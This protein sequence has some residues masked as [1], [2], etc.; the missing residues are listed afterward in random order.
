MRAGAAE[1]DG[2]GAKPWRARELEGAGRG[3]G[4]GRARWLGAGRSLAGARQAPG[5]RPGRGSCVPPCRD[6]AWGPRPARTVGCGR[7]DL[8]GEFR[9]GLCREHGAPSPAGAPGPHPAGWH[10]LPVLVQ[11]GSERVLSLPRALRPGCWAARQSLPAGGSGRLSPETGA[12]SPRLPGA[13]GSVQC[14]CARGPE[15]AALPSSSLSCLHPALPPGRRSERKTLD[16]RP[17]GGLRPGLSQQRGSGSCSSLPRPSVAPAAR[18]AKQLGG[19]WLGGRGE[20]AVARTPRGPTASEPP[21]PSP[22]QSDAVF[23]DLER[24]KSRPAHLGV[25]LRYLFSQ[26]DPGPLVRRRR[27]PAPSARWCLARRCLGPTGPAGRLGTQDRTGGPCGGRL[28]GAAGEPD[29]NDSGRRGS[30]EEVCG[31]RGQQGRGPRGAWAGRGRG[32]EAEAVSSEPASRPRRGCGPPLW[33][34]V[35]S[36]SAAACSCSL[37]G[38]GGGPRAWAVLPDGAGTLVT[39][40]RA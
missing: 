39:E 2:V 16:H 38:R 20:E 6:G 26:A 25:F 18:G 24:L 33:G 34:T 13:C 29:G 11:T 32:R 36:G 28:A 17:R 35:G 22:F 14:R 23:Q 10:P 30:R 4:R 1:R 19:Q 7:R 12:G 9:R 31:G 5:L 27:P 3:S 21:R 8:E 37:N 40:I 15:G